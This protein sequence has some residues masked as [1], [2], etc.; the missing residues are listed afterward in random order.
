MKILKHKEIYLHDYATMDDLVDHLPHFLDE[1][2]NRR[3][4]H[5]P[6][7]YPPPEEFETLNLHPVA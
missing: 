7:G 3:R 6:L 1:F 4:L 2:Y 5:S